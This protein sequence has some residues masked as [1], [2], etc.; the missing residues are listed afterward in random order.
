MKDIVAVYIDAAQAKVAALVADPANNP[1]WMEGLDRYQPVSG[2]A[3]APGSTY[4]LVQQGGKLDFLATVVRRDLPDEVDLMLSA[5]SVVVSVR[6]QFLARGNA[7]RL[8][9]AET[10]RFKGLFGPFIGLLSR[11]AIRR[12]HRAQML[13]FKRFVEAAPA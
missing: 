7:T 9:S 12:A 2:E 1:K 5:D 6:A 8:V 10:F 4:R 3:G 11:R 13:A